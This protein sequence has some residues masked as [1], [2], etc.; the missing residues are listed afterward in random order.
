MNEGC[1][2]ASVLGD[3][4]TERGYLGCEA[5]HEMR[6]GRVEWVHQGGGECKRKRERGRIYNGNRG[7]GRRKMGKRGILGVVKKNNNNKNILKNGIVK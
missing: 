1:E 4:E 5:E 2:G 3:T 7:R 6:L